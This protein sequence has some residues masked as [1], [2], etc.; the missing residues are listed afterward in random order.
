M[1]QPP[2]RAEEQAGADGAADGDHLDLARLQPL[3]IAMLMRFQPGFLG[4]SIGSGRCGGPFNR[5]H[6]PSFL[7]GCCNVAR[8]S[9]NG[10]RSRRFVSPIWNVQSSC[11]QR[12]P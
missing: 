6:R 11:Q 1:L 4:V 2:A 7:R 5:A 3:G 9:S 8:R 12:Y 10:S